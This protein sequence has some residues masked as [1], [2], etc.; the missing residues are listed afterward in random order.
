[1][2][3]R[4]HAHGEWS[5]Y[6]KTEAIKKAEFCSKSE[7]NSAI[8]KAQGNLYFNTWEGRPQGNCK[9]EEK[10]TLW[11]RAPRKWRKWA[12][13]FCS[14]LQLPRPTYQWPQLF[15][16]CPNLSA[17]NFCDSSRLGCTLQ[18]VI[19]CQTGGGVRTQG[20]QAQ[21]WLVY[22]WVAAVLYYY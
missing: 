17:V 13:F 20:P 2:W 16:S 15:K 5:L 1:M 4:Y 10:S 8:C 3:I 11:S 19:R 12:L 9:R 7:Q 18:C 14:F 21:L 6:C 22:F